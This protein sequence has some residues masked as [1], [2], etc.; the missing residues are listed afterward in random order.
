VYSY[1]FKMCSS[2]YGRLK[3]EFFP[4]FLVKLSLGKLWRAVRER[5]RVGG[6]IDGGVCCDDSVVL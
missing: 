5:F 1:L 6:G 4:F 3:I 2:S